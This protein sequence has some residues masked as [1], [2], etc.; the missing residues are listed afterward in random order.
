VKRLVAAAALVAVLVSASAAAG[1]Y[2]HGAQIVSAHFGRLEQA[3]DASQFAAISADGRYVAYQTRARNLF[4]DADADPP[5]QFRVGGIFRFDLETR[6][7]Q[8]VADGELRDEETNT[9]LVRGAQNPSINA[10]GR[11]VAFSTAHQLVPEDDNDNVDVYVRD[12]AVPIRSPGAFDLVSARD[13]GD[14][15]ASYGPPGTPFPPG[16]PGSE[17]SRGTAISHDG[18]QVVFRTSDVASDLPDSAAVDTPGLQVFVRNRTANTTTLVTRRMDTGGPA[19]GALGPAGISGDGTTVVWTGQDAPLQTEFVEGENTDVP[20]F[21]Y[22]LWRRVADG[23]GAPTRRITG[24][25]DP[26]DPACQPS[27]PVF[28]DEF[29]TGP[30]YGPLARPELGI[31]AN[32]NLLPAISSNGYRVAFLTNSGP[33]PNFFAGLALDLYV[34]DMSPGLSRKQATVELTRE[35]NGEAEGAQLESAAMSADG[36]YVAVTSA[37]TRFVL[38]ALAQVGSPRAIVDAAELYVVDL[39][40]RTVE[41]VTR[42]YTGGDIDSTVVSDVTLSGDGSRVAFTSFASNLFF[43]DGNARPDAFVAT[44]QPEP[45]PGGGGGPGPGG[46]G[47]GEAILEDL[48]GDE[49][50]LPASVRSLGRGIVELRVRVP[51]AGSLTAAARARVQ[52]AGRQRRERRVLARANRF[53]PRSSRVTMRLRV[54]RRYRSLL[55]RRGSLLARVNLTFSPSRGGARQGRAL[56]VTFRQ[57]PPGR[58]KPPRARR[59][60]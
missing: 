34:T 23:P 46:P 22:Y 58:A 53:A 50:V 20:G 44:R 14:E 54:V 37:R 24:V 55:R 51:A 52:V 47:A 5:G 12:M 9:L 40:T 17:V 36:R 1:F 10:D 33:R 27:G 25:A 41:R 13:G 15:P 7:T 18:S 6:E 39:A 38:P 16:N 43:G 59:N 11:F 4:A 42:S 56:R 48:G 29:S 3:D 32:F 31:S 26:D 21:L 45:A 60:G 49:V 35:G 57:K 2:G 19:G 30:C 8:L 28:F